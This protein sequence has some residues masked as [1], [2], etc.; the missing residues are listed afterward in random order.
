M[1]LFTGQVISVHWR[2]GGPGFP[3]RVLVLAT[4]SRRYRPSCCPLRR[5][6]RRFSDDQEGG[7]TFGDTSGGKSPIALNFVDAWPAR[8]AIESGII[9]ESANSEQV[10]PGARGGTLPLFTDRPRLPHFASSPP[11]INFQ[12]QFVHHLRSYTPVMRPPRARIRTPARAH[13]ASQLNRS[14]PHNEPKASTLN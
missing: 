4:P 1:R 2:S 13:G 7:P 14:G 6:A 5:G 9:S 11:C 3:P 12:P 8:A 10:Q